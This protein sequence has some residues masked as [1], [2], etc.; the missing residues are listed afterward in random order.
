MKTVMYNDVPRWLFWTLYLLH[1]SKIALFFPLTTNIFFQM[2]KKIFFQLTKKISFSNYGCTQPGDTWVVTHLSEMHKTQLLLHP[3]YLILET[4]DLGTST[5]DSNF[6]LGFLPNFFWISSCCT[7]RISFW[8][9][10]FWA[11]AYLIKTF[12]SF[13]FKKYEGQDISFIILHQTYQ[14]DTETEKDDVYDPHLMRR[15][16]FKGACFIAAR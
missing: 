6:L 4:R 13:K 16:V 3:A 15:K 1:P 10:R 14:T 8:K 2:T 9:P 7:R 11:Q 5:F 12:L